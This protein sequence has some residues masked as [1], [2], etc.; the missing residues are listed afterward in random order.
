MILV[1]IPTNSIFE[2]NEA[3]TRVW[4]MLDQGLDVE[5]IVQHL[6]DEFV[7]DEARAADEVKDLLLRFQN[8]GLLTG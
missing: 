3:G 6:I 7:V 4:E 1:H 8:D 2:L 5:G